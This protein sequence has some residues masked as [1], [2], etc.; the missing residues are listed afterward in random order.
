MKIL[1]IVT[2]FSPFVGGLE[3]LVLDIA[4]QQV[5][6]NEIFVLTL[7]YDSLLPKYE[8]RNNLKIFRVPAFKILKNQYSIPQKGF[9]QKIKE[10]KP[11]VVFT[12][13]RFF[14]T[15]FLGGRFIKKNLPKTKWIH[16]EHGQNS[17]QSKNLIVF[18]GAKIFDKILGKWI[19]K[20]SDKIVV[21]SKTGKNFVQSFKIKKEKIKIIPNGVKIPRKKIPIPQKNKALFFGRI[22]REK[23][24]FEVLEVAQKSPNWSFEICGKLNQKIKNTKN[25]KVYGEMPQKEIIEKI[26][27]VDL[28]ILPSYSEGNSLA[29]LES[30]ACERAILATPVGQNEKIISESFLI[31]LKNCKKIIEKLNFLENNWKELK[32][33]GIKNRKIVEA[34]FS[35]DSMIK[36]YE[37]IL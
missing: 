19:F 20:K 6:K 17:V 31:P 16:V 11:D 33:E 21:L 23:G 1:H 5:K 35:F 9:S 27:S 37:S 26:K 24:I 29:V 22:I 3:N 14:L 30:A 28:V 25:I 13:T 10:I 2:H 7:Q 15:S 18:L 32:K 12:H 4:E 36:S 34:N 8:E